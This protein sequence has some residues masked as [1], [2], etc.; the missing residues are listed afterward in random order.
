[1]RL[2]APLM[3]VLVTLT[4]APSC[5]RPG[6]P[7]R[8]LPDD[9][10]LAPA[11]SVELRAACALA[12]HR[13]SRCHPIDRVLLVDVATPRQ[14]QDQ[15]TRMRR[16]AGSSISPGDGDAIVRCLVYRSFGPAGL[17]ALEPGGSGASSP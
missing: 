14:W 11:A 3:I 15:V 12:E 5:Q 10:A 17:A 9:H 13:C 4:S 6:S 2:P 1:M 8:L 16:L 7:P